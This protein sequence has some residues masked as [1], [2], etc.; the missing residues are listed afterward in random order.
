MNS[1]HHTTG[2][3]LTDGYVEVTRCSIFKQDLPV[4]EGLPASFL[5]PGQVGL[6]L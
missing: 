4:H 3:D 1:D 5:Y 2:F 6:P